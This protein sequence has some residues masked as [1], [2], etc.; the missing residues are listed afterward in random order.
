MQNLPLLVNPFLFFA[1]TFM[2]LL[3]VCA[4]P[5]N[6][7]QPLLLFLLAAIVG[8]LGVA[9]LT[10]VIVAVLVAGALALLGWLAWQPVVLAKF[11]INHRRKK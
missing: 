8:P 9:A 2:I 10:V 5:P 7:R 11:I 3:A 4:M 1:G 6:I